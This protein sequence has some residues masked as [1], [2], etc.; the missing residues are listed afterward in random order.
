MKLCKRPIR[1]TIADII[2]ATQKNLL[3]ATP[4]IKLS[5][6]EWIINL[7]MGNR[8]SLAGVQ[9]TVLTDIRSN[10]VLDGSLDVEALLALSTR[11]FAR[12][13]TLPRLHAKVYVADSRLALVTSA[14]L[15]PSGLDGNIEYGICIDIPEY[16]AGVRADFEAYSRVGNALA[17]SVLSHLTSVARE[18]RKS[19]R[20]VQSTAQRSLKQEFNRELRKADRVFLEA[21]VGSRT[22][23]SLFSEAILYIL[24]ASPMAIR[25]LHPQV[26]R[27]LPDLCNDEVELIQTQ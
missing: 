24:S 4:Y 8:P 16:V 11:C 23:S 20:A 15:T 14:N 9:A 2:L 25:K 13:V 18:V 7:I 19:Y 6:A 22:A 17:P 1:E 3:V 10:S 12:V 26:Q 27:L 5:E 21:Q